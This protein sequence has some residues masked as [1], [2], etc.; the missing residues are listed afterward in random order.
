MG[1]YGRIISLLGIGWVQKKKIR[2][3]SSKRRKNNI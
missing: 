3:R 1:S 2:K